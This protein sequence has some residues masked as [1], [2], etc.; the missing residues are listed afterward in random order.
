MV[1]SI[2]RG[3]G[4][5]AK[6]T[7]NGAISVL[8]AAPV[9]RSRIIC[10]QLAVLLSGVLILMLYSTALELIISCSQFQD[11]FEVPQMLGNVGEKTEA[12]KYFTFFTLFDGNGLVANQ[13][14]AIV[15][16]ILLLAGAIVMY[17]A[18]CIL[19]CKKDL[20]L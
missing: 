12:A 9:K 1:F 5:V 17:I 2:L 7:E 3:N 4:L 18:G 16:A 15:G 11:E 8:V 6:Y 19:F 13:T 14:S 20:S 10:T